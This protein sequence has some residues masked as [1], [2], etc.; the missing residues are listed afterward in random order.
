MPPVLL[1]WVAKEP[2]PASYRDSV[3][4]HLVAILAFEFGAEMLFASCFRYDP[5]PIDPRGVV[6]NML[7]MA[8]GQVGDPIALLVLVITNDFLFHVSKPAGNRSGI[9]TA[10]EMENQLPASHFRQGVFPVSVF[11]SW[12]NAC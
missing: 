10:C 3:I 2:N 9:V 6:T 12:D 4:D 5:G 1:Q 8:T 7:G 11:V